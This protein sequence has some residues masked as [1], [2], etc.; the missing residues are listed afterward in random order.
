[1]APIQQHFDVASRTQ[2]RTLVACQDLLVAL[3]VVVPLVVG[4]V[5]TPK[6]CLSCTWQALAPQVTPVS[7]LSR[8]TKGL[9]LPHLVA[10]SL[11]LARASTSRF[12]VAGATPHTAR[13]SLPGL[14]TATTLPLATTPSPPPIALPAT[15]TPASTC[16]TANP[17]HEAASEHPIPARL[18]RAAALDHFVLFRR[19]AWGQATISP[20]M[21]S[22]CCN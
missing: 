4:V 7:P 11:L 1:M 22:S 20:E 21:V 10:Q 5:V 9:A 8:T 2:S 6:A 3:V 18:M 15:S 19:R 16:P 13:H 17:L 12:R 14:A